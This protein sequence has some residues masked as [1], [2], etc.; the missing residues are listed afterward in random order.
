M[1]VTKNIITCIHISSAS[2]SFNAFFCFVF[3]P[4]IA[5]WNFSYDILD[6]IWPAT[7]NITFQIL[8]MDQGDPIRGTR[9]TATVEVSNTCLIDTE[10]FPIDYNFDV[11]STNG[12]MHLRV[13]GY[14]HAD[15]CK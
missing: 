9:A 10:Y 4:P 11:D 7:T 15:F 14:F 1:S 2:A 8:V 6:E 13:P 12:T 5:N 3:S